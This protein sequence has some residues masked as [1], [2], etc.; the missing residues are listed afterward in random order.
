MMTV[1]ASAPGKLMLFGEH[2]VVYGKPCLVTAVDIR[3]MCT[4]QRNGTDFINID[5]PELRTSKEITTISMSSL[6]N[7]SLP[8][9]TQ[10]TAF[11]EA[12]V[13][14]LYEK[15]DFREGF[16]ITTEGAPKQ[17]GLGSSSAITVATIAALDELFSLNLNKREIFDLAYSAVLSVQNGKG[18]GFDVAA[19]VYGGSLYYVIGGK[20]I[21]TLPDVDL[22]LIIG[23][24]GEKASTTSYIR[25]VAELRENH[26][27]R[28]DRFFDFI[29]YLVE[30]AREM[31]IQGDWK[32]FGELANVNQSILETFDISPPQLQNPILAARGAGAWGAKL[33]GAGGGDCMF[34]VVDEDHRPKVEAAINEAIQQRT[35]EEVAVLDFAVNASGVRIE[36]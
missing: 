8:F 29:A 32:T 33:S 6:E 18:S 28:I 26:P 17:Y 1:T 9:R 2:A 12:A 21:E 5:T 20:E 15:H 4:A 10:A 35:L 7:P 23:Y 36:S 22:P 16:D 27:K 3:Y 30:D 34:A 11:V 25:H 31:L 13:R 24:T 14:G 19:A